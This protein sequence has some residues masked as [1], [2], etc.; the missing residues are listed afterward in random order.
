MPTPINGPL[1]VESGMRVSSRLHNS[2]KNRN[3]PL[4]LLLV[5]LDTIIGD[6]RL[7]DF[8]IVPHRKVSRYDLMADSSIELSELLVN[9]TRLGPAGSDSN[10]IVR[11][12]NQTIL[13]FYL[14]D[15]EQS[16]NFNMR[17]NKDVNPDF[18]IRETSYDLMTNPLF[19]I[20]PRTEAMMPFA[21]ITSDAIVVHQKLIL[22]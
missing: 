21:F 9:G 17:M 14:S 8:V 15:A 10:S 19:E 22:K 12:A 3:I 1:P 16:L 4:P 11:S 20:K 5:N 18:S 7:I 2:T 13:T 6:E